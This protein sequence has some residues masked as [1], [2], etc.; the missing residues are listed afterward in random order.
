MNLEDFD[1]D[2]LSAEEI[3]AL[4]KA[5]FGDYQKEVNEI[6]ENVDI[7]SVTAEEFD[8]LI[9]STLEENEDEDEPSAPLLL[10]PLTPL[11]TPNAPRDGVVL[12]GLDDIRQQLCAQNATVRVAAL[13]KALTYGEAGLDLVI[14]VLQ[15][16]R[17]GLADEAYEVLRQRPE[18]KAKDAVARYEPLRSEKGIDY[19]HLRDLLK[20]GKWREAD[21]ETWEVMLRAV[22]RDSEDDIRADEYRTFPCT[23]LQ[24]IDRLWVRY[25]QGRFGFSVQKRICVE[26]GNP[27]DGEFHEDTWRKFADRVGWRKNGEYL[28]CYSELRANPSFSPAGELPVFGW[29]G[30]FVLE[31]GFFILGE[32]RGYPPLLLNLF[33]CTETIESTLEENEDEP[34]APLLL[35]P[36]TPLPTPNAPRDGVARYEPLRSE[37]G[38]DYTRLRDLLKEGKWIEAD[39]ETWAVMRQAVGRGLR[40]YIRADEYHT[41]P[42]TDLQTIDRLWVKYSQGKYGFSVQKQVDLDTR[43]FADRSNWSEDE[44]WMYVSY[45]ETNPHFY[46]A[47]LP[48]GNWT[49]YGRL[50]FYGW[51]W[52]KGPIS[53]LA[54]RLVNC[55]K[56]KSDHQKPVS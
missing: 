5:M 56:S 26:T 52:C 9:E 17:Q 35:N 16:D 12:E 46:P 31:F 39:Q 43:K 30:S 7:D 23:E 34:S 19:T 44:M 1:L 54:Q 33:F 42:C 48:G 41:F 28:Y 37:R 3:R 40:D 2:N 36:L 20:A 45:M 25:S 21:E 32:G 4:S 47:V 13:P 24:I 55:S 38:V 27:L 15:D 53:S 8:D 51:V 10:N 49:C 22:G 18:A 6:L 11:P 50:G 14:E 29:W